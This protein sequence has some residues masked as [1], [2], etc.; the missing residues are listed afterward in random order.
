MAP[1]TGVPLHASVVINRFWLDRMFP[2]KVQVTADLL[3][4]GQT[5]SSGCSHS[6]FVQSGP[7]LGYDI[8]LK[9]SIMNKDQTEG[10]I[11]QVKG[12][13]KEGAGK[14]VGN[15]R[16]KAEGQAAQAKG[17]VQSTWG[18]AREKV[19]D[20]TKAQIDKL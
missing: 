17:K 11:D 14:L 20:E 15:E 9:D 8:N 1:V 6:S 2:T 5:V 12:K 13:I 16:M 19:K 3:S 10:R 4:A 7:G 18:D